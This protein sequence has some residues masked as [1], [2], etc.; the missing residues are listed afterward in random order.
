MHGSPRT[1]PF[2]DPPHGFANDEPSK[3]LRQRPP[4]EAIAWAERV[5]GAPLS[6]VRAYRGG[7]SSAIHGLRVSGSTE[8]VI[9]RRYVLE[10]L[11]LEE[12]DIAEREARVLRLLERCPITTPTLLGVDTTGQAAGVPAILMSRVPGR[13][14]WSPADPDPWLRKLVDVL[15]DLHNTTVVPTDRVQDFQPYRPES[16]DPPAWLRDRKL[17][18]RALGVFHGPRLDTERFFIHRDYHPGNV[19]WRRGRV[20]GVVD[21]Q[22]ASVGPRAADVWHCRGNLVGRF[23]M[24]VA[25]RFLDL[26][27]TTTG[28]AYH[29]WTET[30]MLVDA[31]GW[32]GQRR[33]SEQHALEDLLARRLAELGA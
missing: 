30:V 24:E 23:G 4:P 21:W 11:N 29:P 17:W 31:I 5:V 3:Y 22:A 20:S 10:D 2:S 6:V 32:P 28:A 14:D 19:L 16:W 33:P 15:S 7:S 27:Q 12:P 26:W 25:D 18:D 1:H 9:L 8:T 13:L